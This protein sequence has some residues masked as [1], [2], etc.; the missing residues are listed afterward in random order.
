MKDIIIEKE[1]EYCDGTGMITLILEI[2][3]EVQKKYIYCN[4]TG[5]YNKKKTKLLNKIKIKI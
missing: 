1:C 3:A 2:G 4:G 5:K